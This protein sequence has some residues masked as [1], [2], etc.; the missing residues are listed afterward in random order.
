MNTKNSNSH[1]FEVD[2]FTLEINPGDLHRC[3]FIV[4]INAILHSRLKVPKGQ[5][6]Y[7]PTKLKVSETS[8]SH[9]GGCGSTLKPGGGR[10][11]TRLELHH[12]CLFQAPFE[13][14]LPIAVHTCSMTIALHAPLLRMLP[15]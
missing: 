12:P 3:M 4:G 6:L 7:S 2:S 11:P 14:T 13:Y 5:L 1:N 8:H 15:V 10:A 9:G